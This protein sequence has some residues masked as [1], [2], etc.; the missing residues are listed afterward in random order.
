MASRPLCLAL[1]L[2]SCQ[3]I[4]N[5]QDVSDSGISL[6][7]QYSLSWI[8]HTLSIE[9]DTTT[10]WSTIHG[11]PFVS[12]S[13]GNDSFTGSNGAFNIT[14]VDT[15]RCTGQNITSVEQVPWDGTLT[16]S[17]VQAKGY[18]L[19]CGISHAEYELTFWVPANLTDRV[20]FYLNIVP[21]SG[22]ELKKLYLSFASSPDEDIYGLGAQASF[23]SLKSQ[24]IPVFSR[25]QGVGRGDQPITA[26]LNQNGSFAGGDKFTT[27]TAIASYITTKG[28]MFS[29]SGKDAGYANFDFTVSDL[30]TVRYD[31]L[32][33]DGF[34]ARAGDMFG[35]VERLTAGTGRMP[36][37]PSWVDNG[38]ILGIQG[39]QSKVETIVQHGLNLSCPIAGVW[40]QDWVGTHGQAGPYVN[41]SRLWWN[42]EN[43]EK[44]YPNWPAFVQGLRDQYNVRTLSYVNTFLANVSTKTD[45]FRRNLYAEA[46]GAGYFVQNTTSDSTAII[47]SGPGL[48]AG[49]IDLT[50]PGLRSWFTEVM[51]TQVWSANISGFMSDFGE[52]TPVTSDTKLYSM[53]SDAF[54]AHNEYPL[55]WAHYQKETIDNLG[56]QD[57]ALVFHRSAATGSNK[58]MNLFWVGDQN[59]NWGVNDG[60]KSVVTI[61]L[62][63]GLSGYAHQ[64]SDI[65]GY[66]DTLTYDNYNITRSPELLGRWGELA[67]VS[68]SVFRSHEGNIPS[69]NAQFYS[70]DTTY[71]YYA[72]NARMFVSLAP[73]RRY[74][75][76]T[77]CATKGWPLLRSPVMYHVNDPRTRNISY[78]S[79]YLGPG[80]YVAPVLDPGVEELSVY[81][82]GSAGTTFKHVWTEEVYY[83]GRD[84]VVATP[85]GQ[86][87]VFLVNGTEQV[88][89]E[90]FLDFVKRENETKLSIE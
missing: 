9:E 29:L 30:I 45:G 31:S 59:L 21:Q 22:P 71:E 51:K 28:N 83:G 47:S 4:A 17:A 80:L 55:L 1:S 26:I 20:A 37:L 62:H 36:K 69:V 70:N 42:W 27:Y 73:Y 65:G 11:Q 58:Y 78:Q 3:V 25:E 81:L 61:M 2:Y 15:D 41:V 18:L 89:L 72:Y 79:F 74:I 38:A 66:T 75:L 19:S 39:G 67:A 32:S 88:E 10:V 6:G 64:H 57:E 56:L 86:P 85:L 35:A 68:S 60:I 40:L 43:D 46:D 49:I 84:V 34:F 87:A 23:A 53:V 90:S 54:Y 24:S 5:P 12:A 7:G 63:M 76:E 13:A 82:P 14:Q 8:N 33:M 52:Y 50:N 16:G 77:E 48:V 44:L